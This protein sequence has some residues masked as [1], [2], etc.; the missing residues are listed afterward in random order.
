MSSLCFYI[1][2]KIYGDGGLFTKLKHVPRFSVMRLFTNQVVF[3]G[4]KFF[5]N[6]I[7]KYNG[8]SNTKLTS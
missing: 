4:I 8:M 2:C 7:Q 5:F 6:L 3:D 1:S